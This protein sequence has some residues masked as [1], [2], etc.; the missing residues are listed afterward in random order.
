MPQSVNYCLEPVGSIQSTL[1]NKSEAPMQ[2]YEGAPEAW[3]ITDDEFKEGVEG[4]SVGD[5]IILI[6]WLHQSSREVIKVHP[7]GD[8]NNPLTGVFATRSPDRPNP[9]GLHRVTVLEVVSNRIKVAPLEVIDG[10]PVVD[11]KPVLDASNDS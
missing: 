3:L 9:F 1:K 6:T 2:G 10:T 11:I 4:I 8:I 7:R 5:S